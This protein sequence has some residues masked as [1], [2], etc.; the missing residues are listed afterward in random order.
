MLSKYNGVC[1]TFSVLHHPPLRVKYYLTETHIPLL[2]E[3]Y[4]NIKYNVLIIF[5]TFD[6]STQTRSTIDD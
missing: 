3:Y 1:E 4:L 5:V 6:I 2:L